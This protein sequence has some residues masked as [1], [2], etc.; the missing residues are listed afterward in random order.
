ML[1]GVRFLR[2][3]VAALARLAHALTIRSC[4]LR[5]MPLCSPT[6]TSAIVPA[7]WQQQ[8]ASA[9]AA[10]APCGGK[11]VMHPAGALMALDDPKD[12]LTPPPLSS[13][14]VVVLVPALKQQQQAGERAAETKTAARGRR[15]PRLAIPAPVAC[16]PGVDP[17]GAVADVDAEVATELEVQGEGFC[18]ASRRGVRHAMEDGYGVIT[19]HTVQGASQLAFYGVY[20]GHGGRAAVDFVADKLGKNVVA[21]LAASTTASHHQPELSPSPSPAPPPSKTSGAVVEDEAG[22]EEEQFDAVVAAIRAAYLTTDREFLTQGVRGGACAA[23]ALVK[24]GELFVANVGD[25]RAVLGSRSGVATALTS[26]HTAA[27]E[28]ERRRIESSVSDHRD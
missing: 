26:D 19:D 25:C 28:D 3:T 24:D 5:L 17:F 16:A 15:P 10:A 18:L 12:Q 21:A 23:T 11:K 27:R 13:S 14:S 20:D 2:S 4:L 22:Q 1:H 8:P 6:S 7:P 9:R